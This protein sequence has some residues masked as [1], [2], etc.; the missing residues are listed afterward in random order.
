MYELFVLGELLNK[1]V[2]GYLLHQIVQKAIGPIRQ[3]SWGA[4]YPLLR[5]LEKEGLIRREKGGGEGGEREKKLYRITPAG[6][7]R[8]RRLMA[9]PGAYDADYPDL[10]TLKMSKFQ[11]IDRGAQLAILR[12]Y[13]GYVRYIESYVVANYRHVTGEPNIPQ[14]ERPYIL[15][16]M[17]R[18]LHVARAE[19][20]WL[21]AEI[22]ALAGEGNHEAQEL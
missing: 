19:L 14:E 22:A 18:R 2:H 5:R 16:G 15:R 9:E 12:H 13:Q 7:A 4:L 17:D 8:F 20:A 21:E 3:M 10:F 11:H 6:E 1:P